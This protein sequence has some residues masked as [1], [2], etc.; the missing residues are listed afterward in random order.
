M[1]VLPVVGHVSSLRRL[2]CWGALG[3]AS[4][5]NLTMSRVVLECL[6]ESQILRDIT[7]NTQIVDTDVPQNLLV[8]DNESASQGNS[9]IIEDSVVGSDLLLDI[10]QEG[11]VDAAETSE[12]SGL[13]GP[14]SMDEVRVDRAAE[15]LTVVISEFFGLIAELNN[16]GGADEGE[17]ERVEKEQNPLVLVVI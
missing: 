2:H 3:P 5:T 8:V 1:D 10:S 13:L 9:S 16:F 17:V 11:N 4:R 14:S 12:I 15:H 6:E 7:T